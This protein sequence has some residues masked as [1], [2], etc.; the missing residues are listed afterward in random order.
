[1][2]IAAVPQVLAPGTPYAPS[3]GFLVGYR[4]AAQIDLLRV[5]N[6]AADGVLEGNYSRYTL[7][8]AGSAGIGVNSLGYDTRD[9]VID[10]SERKALCDKTA[11]DYLDCLRKGPQ[12]DVYLA[13][14]APS[15]LVIGSLRADASYASGSSDLPAFTEPIPLTTGPS[16]LVA[17]AVRVPAAVGHAAD[18]T[19]GLIDERGNPYDLEQRVFVVCFDS[20]RIFIYDPKRHAIDSIIDVGRGPYSLVVDEGRGLG[21]VGFF[22]DSYLGVVSLDQ[23]YPQTYA[24]VIA[25]IGAPTPPR[26]S[27]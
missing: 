23:R 24:A 13:S 19:H 1:M 10:D 26:T 11:A 12:P 6:D 5:R 27:K 20:T 8:Y 15:S 3:P 7:T 2:A 18:P 21:Y 9:I 4:N 16:R 25:N 22:T 14:R 17:A